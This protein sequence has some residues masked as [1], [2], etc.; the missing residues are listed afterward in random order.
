M[1]ETEIKSI[2]YNNKIT[3]SI[4]RGTYAKNETIPFINTK[5]PSAYIINYDTRSEEG[6]HWVAIFIRNDILFYFDS[7]CLDFTLDPLMFNNILSLK[8][9]FIVS[10]PARLQ[11]LTTSTCGLYCLLFIYFLARNIPYSTFLNYFKRNDYAYNEKYVLN[12][13]SKIFN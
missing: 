12:L 11:S 9:L 1:D 3:R 10:N 4:F 8:K 2:M 13:Y 7:L 6:S 5:T